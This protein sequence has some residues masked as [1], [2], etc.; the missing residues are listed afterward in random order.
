MAGLSST[1]NMLD[2]ALDKRRD[3]L[4]RDVAFQFND[5]SPLMANL[6]MK[7]EPIM[8]WETMRYL[9]FQEIPQFVKLV[10]DLP[11]INNRPTPYA[12]QLATAGFSI[13]IP[14][15]YSV[16]RRS[17]G[18]GQML[19]RK[20]RPALKGH[21][22]NLAEKFIN[23]RNTGGAGADLDLDCFNGI[24]YRLT[25][26]GRSKTG[27]ES[28]M[29]VDAATIGAS[30][31]GTGFTSTVLANMLSGWDQML[32]NMGSYEGDGVIIIA[33]SLLRSRISNSY[34]TSQNS[35]FG[36]DTDALGKT[37]MTYRNAKV[38]LPGWTWPKDN[39]AG[40]NR[41]TQILAPTETDN[42][43]FSTGG[44][45]TSVFFVR[46]GE[47]HLTFRKMKDDAPEALNLRDGGIMYES[48][49]W[50]MYGI[51]QQDP[52]AIGQIHNID[53]A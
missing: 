17:G 6:T 43:N 25:T 32:Y 53:L 23:A 19:K 28:F 34:L 3:G 41:Q 8:D 24:R 26:N 14:K 22:M 45:K 2:F 44:T 52:N 16:D 12:E 38:L 36:N 39:S 40:G 15:Q 49:F 27:A 5:Y 11:I 46:T 29:K 21:V 10:Q 20:M 9:N 51:D 42:G 30:T 31:F 50:N 18:I 37:V 13:Q 33:N 1:Y 47:E 7:V 48:V 4:A 35:I